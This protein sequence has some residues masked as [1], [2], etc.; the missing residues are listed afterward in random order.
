[1]K[2]HKNYLLLR[3]QRKMNWADQAKYLSTLKMEAACV[4]F[5]LIDRSLCNNTR[6]NAGGENLHYY[7][8]CV[9]RRKETVPS[10]L[11]GIVP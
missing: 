1:M 4:C 11:Q 8:A 6:N 2:K 10:A 3:K 7:V 9:V 5:L